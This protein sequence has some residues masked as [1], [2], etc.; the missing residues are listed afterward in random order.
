MK[1]LLFVTIFCITMFS[2]ACAQGKAVTVKGTVNYSRSYCGGAAPSPEMI[3]NL[4]KVVPFAQQ[5]LHFVNAAN[6]SEILKTKTTADG[7]FELKL[8]KG[9]YNIYTDEKMRDYQPMMKVPSVDIKMCKQWAETPV[10]IVGV[11]KK[12]SAP[13]TYTFHQGCCPCMPPR[14]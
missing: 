1:H 10:F 13:K 2:S 9:T 5:T 7:M 12:K 11:V 14:P 3:E 8:K 6:P 4:A